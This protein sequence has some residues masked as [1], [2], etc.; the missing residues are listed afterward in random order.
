MRPSE[1][2]V[3]AKTNNKRPN[4]I[5]IMTHWFYFNKESQIKT[6]KMAV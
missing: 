4:L 3:F 5:S 6:C 2:T 1:S